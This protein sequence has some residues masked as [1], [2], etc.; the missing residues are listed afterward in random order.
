MRGRLPL[1]R[2][3]YCGVVRV[4]AS[5]E[6]IDLVLSRGGQLYVWP[7]RSLGC[8][9]LS[10]L[11]AAWAPPRGRRFDRADF[12]P[13]ALYLAAIGRWPQDLALQVHRRRVRALWDGGAWA[14]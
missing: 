2:F 4:S 14:I 9:P 3:L 6:A 13:F 12:A 1:P 11:E 7:A 10:R 5:A 8:Q